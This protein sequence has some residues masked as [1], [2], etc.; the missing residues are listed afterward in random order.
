LEKE[1]GVSF[2]GR[3]LVVVLSIF[4]HVSIMRAERC[5]FGFFRLE[6]FAD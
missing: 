1:K 6:K 5:I 2:W 3:L 4:N